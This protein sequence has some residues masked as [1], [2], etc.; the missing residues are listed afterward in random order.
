[1]E[2]VRN[3]GTPTVESELAVLLTPD[4]ARFEALIAGLMSPDNSRRKMAELVFT[5][6]KNQPDLC[7]QYLVNTLRRSAAKENRAFCAL[8]LRKVL[9]KEDPLMWPRLSKQVQDMVKNELLVG[10]GE[11]QE[12]DV[13][14]KICHAVS[15]LGVFAAE[16]ED[17]WQELVPMLVQLLQSGT[18]GLMESALS[19]VSALALR[20]EADI[21]M[22]IPGLHS[23]LQSSLNQESIAVRREAFSATCA[24]VQSLNEAAQRNTFQPLVPHMLGALGHFLR[25]GDSEAANDALENMIEVA[26]TTP[27]FLRKQLQDIVNAMVQMAMTE[28]L[29]AGVRS[30]ATEFL[31]TVCERKEQ[32]PQML[33]RMPN[34]VQQLFEV[35]MPFLLDIEDVIEWHQASELEDEDSG[36]GELYEFGQECLDRVAIAFKGKAVVPVAGQMLNIWIQDQDW[37][38]RHATLICL[39]QIA[40]GCS[41]VM[42]KE[43]DALT[44]MCLGGLADPVAKVRWAACQAIGQMCTDLG[45]HLQASQHQAVVPRILIAM[46]ENENPR[47][48]AHATAALVNFCEACELDDLAPYLDSLMEKLIQLLQCGS[49]VVQ[50]GALTALASVADRAQDAFQ[51]YYESVMPLLKS[52]LLSATDKKYQMLRAKALECVSLVGMAVGLECFRKD[53][54]DILQFLNQLNNSHLEADDPIMSYMLQVSDLLHTDSPRVEQKSLSITR[55]N[56]ASGSYGYKFVAQSSD[57]CHFLA[58]ENSVYHYSVYCQFFASK[59]VYVFLGRKRSSVK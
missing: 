17:G 32:I 34:F 46:D 43:I 42:L 41:K 59:G 53:A 30:L 28:S 27:K 52:V 11:E 13:C 16:A 37:K 47:I 31:I 44:E 50:E 55:G 21:V 36:H 58:L 6:L 10:L 33:K 12:R 23:C 25:L 8:L 2:R 29:E 57:C 19:I 4:S 9:T 49:K 5:Q 20:H 18:P 40:E 3:M 45:P 38:K 7:T 56:C 26:D 39:A 24:L 14:R 35:L 1:M 15:E 54:Q 22:Q 51:K 48:Q